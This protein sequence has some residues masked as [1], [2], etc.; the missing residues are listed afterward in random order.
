[1]K[2]QIVLLVC[3]YLVIGN[4]F[5][6]ILDAGSD[7]TICPGEVVRLQGTGDNSH[8]FY[9]RW[10]PDST[11]SN[12]SVLNPWAWPS[13]TTTYY[14]YGYWAD[15]N[16]VMNGN[17]ELGNTGFTSSYVYGTGSSGLW[18]EGTYSVVNYAYQVHPNFPQTYD[19]TFGTTTGHYMAVNG[20]GVANTV[21]WSQNLSVTPNTDYIFYTWV[22]TLV[23]TT[24]AELAQLQFSINGTL[25]GNVFSAPS[26]NAVGW[27]QFYTIWNSGSS[28]TATIT[29]VNQ[30]IATGS[31]DFGLDDIYFA[32][33]VPDS[34]SVT[35]LIQGAV[36][37]FQT[38][39][40]CAYSSYVFNRNI[41]V[42]SGTYVD[43]VQTSEGCDSILVLDITFYPPV[44]VDLGDDLTFCTTDT[45]S[46]FLDPGTG[47]DAY[48]WNNGD[49]TRKIEV[50]SSGTYSV[51][52]ANEIGCTATDE[53]NVR[54]SNPPPVEIINNTD[55]FCKE[56]SATLSL[57]TDA[58]YILWS[59][60]EISPE[61]E[62]FDFDT[63]YV[64]VSD[65]ADFFCPA[66]D[67]LAIEFC[68][69]VDLKLPNV[70][71]PSDQNDINDFFEF[72]EGT[73]F[74]KLEIN[75]YNRWGK[76]VFNSLNP[77]FRWDGTI[78]GKLE[79][80]VFYYVVDLK[81]GCEFHGSITVF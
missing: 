10:S 16:I 37:T 41:I 35:V 46:V 63:F 24:P 52:V 75:I 61:I 17:F 38:I 54:F 71:T 77:A 78:N 3:I 29:I 44:E 79:T 59:N 40:Q 62:V 18:P 19:H 45:A 36:T 11:L 42:E 20:S 53:I 8:Y 69:P 70:I 66:Y 21:V 74:R 15:S 55:D 73:P 6:Q 43:T 32:P 48:L 2:R 60:G 33:I 72:P 26:S 25:V 13:I 51:T 68:C 49:S 30:N 57:N 34:D 39:E 12:S 64:M 56:Y 81:D 5:S 23:G 50:S 4:A 1:M 58:S 76:L 80:G 9:Y 65:E 47:F 67:T 31:N 22:L 14:L 28:A 7:Q 27:Q